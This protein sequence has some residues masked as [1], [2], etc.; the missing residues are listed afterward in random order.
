MTDSDDL[1]TLECDLETDLVGEVCGWLTADAVAFLQETVA[2]AVRVE[3]NR[4]I[5]AGDLH[6]TLER[7]EK[8]RAESNAL[9]GF[10]GMGL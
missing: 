4:Y 1:R 5:A 8:L 2:H 3:F 6:K 9:G 10:V 7:M